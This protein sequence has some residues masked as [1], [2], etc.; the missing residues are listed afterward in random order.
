MCFTFTVKTKPYAPSLFFTTLSPIQLCFIRLLVGKPPKLLSTTADTSNLTAL[1]SPRA[2]PPPA[3]VAAHAAAGVAFESPFAQRNS[4]KSAVALKE[5]GVERMEM[6]QSCCDGRGVRGHLFITSH[7]CVFVPSIMKIEKFCSQFPLDSSVSIQNPKGHQTCIIVEHHVSNDPKA[8][9]KHNSVQYYFSGFA[10]DVVCV[11]A[12]Q[13]MSAISSGTNQIMAA[14]AAV[15]SPFVSPLSFFSPGR[16]LVHTATVQVV[17]AT[18]PHNLVS[19]EKTVKFYISHC[20]EERKIKPF[21]PTKDSG[22]IEV[23]LP[24]DMMAPLVLQLKGSML[25]IPTFEL[26]RAEVLNW[27]PLNSGSKHKRTESHPLFNEQKVEVCRVTLSICVPNLGEMPSLTGMW[28]PSLSQ[29]SR[30]YA[31][32]VQI[33][34]TAVR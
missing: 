33:S 19:S 1:L 10:S 22:P 21:P 18:L 2:A 12:F 20:G 28:P 3:A 25:G 8:V 13:K 29:S 14:G 5:R 24:T 31:L 16:Q 15:L 23:S 27:L 11:H 7:R 4:I 30:L 9:Q 6:M 26:G 17:S 32:A 34:L